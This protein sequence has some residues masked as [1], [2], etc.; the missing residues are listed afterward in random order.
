MELTELEDEFEKLALEVEKSKVKLP[1]KVKKLKALAKQI[2]I[3]KLLEEVTPC[4]WEAEY[5]FHDVRKWRFDFALPF[6]KIAIEI[7][8]GVWTGG[9]HVRGS[10]FINDMEKLNMAT[11]TD[12]KV[13][14]YTPSQLLIMKHDVSELI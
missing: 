8:G 11:K 3:I 2:Y 6:H 5:K 9:R 13:L 10:G 7:N 4:G 12:W 1:K 14:Q